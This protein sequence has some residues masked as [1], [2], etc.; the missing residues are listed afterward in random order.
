VDELSM[1]PTSLPGVA[2]W[3]SQMDALD[4]KRFASRVM[5]LTTAEKMVRAFKEAYEY[6]RHQKKGSWIK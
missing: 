1:N 4:A 2:D 6:I 5:R 3:I